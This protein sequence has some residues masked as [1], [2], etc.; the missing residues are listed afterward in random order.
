MTFLFIGSS[1]PFNS[2]LEEVPDSDKVLHAVVYAVLAGLFCRSLEQSGAGRAAA[3]V[4]FLLAVLYGASDEY[5]Q[6][7]VPSRSGTVADW[8]ADSVGAMLGAAAW[9][10]AHR[11]REK[12]WPK[13]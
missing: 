3:I 2:G 12:K 7:M 8:L 1:L 10:G 6:V 4:G 13:R 11:Y 5:H 9:W